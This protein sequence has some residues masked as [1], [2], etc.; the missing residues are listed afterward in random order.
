MIVAASDDL[1][2]LGRDEA[3]RAALRQEHEGELPDL[4]ERDADD[5]GDA[6]S[7]TEDEHRDRGHDRLPDEDQREGGRDG[8]RPRRQDARVEQHSDRDEEE[9]VEGVAE[10]GDV[11]HGLVPEVGIRDD[12][13]RQER[14]D[15]EREPDARGRERRAEHEEQHREKKE[16]LAPRRGD[17][18]KDARDHESRGEEHEDH[19]GGGLSDGEDGFQ[20]AGCRAGRRAVR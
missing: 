6:R 15:G 16:L 13:S 5:R 11:G 2:D 10:R 19:R 18:V 17:R 4:R 7:V 9:R 14:S 3:R 12:Q 8:R 1:I 20:D